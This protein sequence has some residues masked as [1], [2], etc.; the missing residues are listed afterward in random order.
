MMIASPESVR[1]LV[2]A[3]EARYGP[4][5]PIPHTDPLD[6]LVACILSQ[7]T[8]DANSIPA[9]ER[10]K[11]TFPDWQ[12][13]V[14]AGD[15]AVANVI[16]NAGLANQKSRSII[17]CLLEIRER[18][19]SYSLENLRGMEPIQ[20]RDWLTSL[21]GVGPKTASIVLCFSL[22]MGVI[23]VDTHVFRVSWRLGLVEE[24]AGEGKAHDTL[25]SIVPNELAYRFH[26][27]LIQHGRAVCK[28]PLPNC[29]ACCVASSCRWLAQGGP[30]RKRQEL[31]S[32]RKMPASKGKTRGQ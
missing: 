31:A 23:P 5:P 11:E 6:E 28:A 7:H 3:L 12:R 1:S 18:V 17:R 19:G 9:F 15:E 10:L 26:M 8:S 13:L 22:G 4:A 32:R 21:P 20:A 14:D 25:L 2:A 29:E 24:K 16:R 30:E 27:A